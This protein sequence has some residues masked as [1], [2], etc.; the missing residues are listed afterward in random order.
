DY[1]D[2]IEAHVREVCDRYGDEVD[3]FFF[4]ILMM[5]SSADW[6]DS[7]LAFRRKHGLMGTDEETHIRFE[8]A[9]QAA[10][11][12]RFTNLVKS[13]APR[14]TVFYNSGHHLFGDATQGSRMRVPFSTHFEV[15]SLPSG[16]WGYF[17]F[18]RA[19]RLT[20]NWTEENKGETPL[21]WLAMTGRFQRQ[22]GD[23][24]G[25][26]PQPAL[27]FECFRAQALGGANSVGDQ[28]PPRGVLDAA[29][30][31][32][33]GAV[34]AQCEAAEPFYEGSELLKHIGIVYPGYAGHDETAADKSIEGAVQMCEEAHYECGVLDDACDF[35]G[36]E[37]IVLPDDVV[38]TPALKEK[39]TKYHADGGKLLIS[40]RSGFDAQGNWALD[41]LPLEFAGETEK[42][43]T[44]WRASGAFNATLAESD[45]VVYERGLNVLAPGAEVLVERVLPYFKR[46]DVRFCSHF[47]TPPIKETDRFPA[48]VA[49]NGFIYF[50]DPI[51]REYRQ[52]GNIA[53]RD[54]WKTA[55]QRLA[56]TPRLGEGLPTSVFVAPRRRGNDLI[57][58]LLHYIPVRKSLDIDIIEERMTFAGETLRIPGAK[59]A[60]IFGG[61]ELT[62]TGDGEFEL[63]TVK[64]RLL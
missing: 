14:A 31:N 16:F 64:G 7:G 3:G 53:A 59:S 36:Y 45:R 2:Y 1:Q 13:L 6:S 30:Y 34:F 42:W 48:V 33:I 49:G 63:P 60:R 50:A 55:M 58:T 5:H 10:F 41:F 32:L 35:S 12:E 54:G 28:L 43:P 57:V 18:P 23:F 51:F 26:K 17:H 9:A 15:E 19:A 4:D 25:I 61:A 39:L 8:T 62:A 56:P 46:D 27:E 20:M 29:A 21:P 52:A 47:Q 11:C 24:G 22:W 38:I 37:T 40:H 44:F